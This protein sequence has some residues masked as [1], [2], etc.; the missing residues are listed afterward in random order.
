VSAAGGANFAFDVLG[1][2]LGLV[3]GLDLRKKRAQAEA[4]L[5]KRYPLQGRSPGAGGITTSATPQPPPTIRNR[6]Q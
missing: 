6:S 1:L 2:A 3:D 4:E 5:S